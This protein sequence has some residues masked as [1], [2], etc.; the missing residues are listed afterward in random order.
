MWVSFLMESN[1]M[2]DQMFT[3]KERLGSHTAQV[4]VVGLGFV[5]LP[6]AVELGKVG[7]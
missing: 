6:L 5:G 4:V 7:F 1:A 2:S 3:L